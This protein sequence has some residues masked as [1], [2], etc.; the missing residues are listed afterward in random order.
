MAKVLL[1]AINLIALITYK[2]FFG[3][4]VTVDQNFPEMVNAGET[5]TIDVTIEK[6]DRQGFAKWQST[7][8]EGFI[9]SATETHGA[10]FSFKNQDVKVIWMTLPEEE[11]FTIS[12]EVKSD[13][14]MQ[15]S[16]E[17]GGK[18]SFI[19]ENERKDISSATKVITVGSGAV[20]ASENETSE[21]E[22]EEMAD[23]TESTSEEEINMAEEIPADSMEVAEMT[24]DTESSEVET[25]TNVEEPVAD[26][27]MAEG[28][29]SSTENMVVAEEGNILIKRQITHI[30]EGKYEVSLSINKSDYESFGKVEDYLPPNFI[31]SEINNE[32]GMFS[33]NNNVVKI[34]WMTIPK[35]EVLEVKYALESVSDDL[36]T[37]GIHGMFSFLDN[38]DSRQIQIAE[39]R[40]KNYF[41]SEQ[42]ADAS[43][44]SEEETTDVTED[45]MTEMEE[46]DQVAEESSENEEAVEPEIAE[47]NIE[48]EAIETTSSEEDDL[49]SEITNI[50]APDTDVNYRVQIAAAKREVTQQYFIDRHNIRENVTIEFHE[51]WYKYTIG[52]YGIYKEARD[53]RNEVWATENKIDDAF[54][55][56]YNAGERISVQEALMITKQQWFK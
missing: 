8:P 43:E 39:T 47:N 33:F 36:D 51:T 35:Q 55:T 22:E 7:L 15:G 2:L 27:T 3:G 6:G 19:E 46:S 28:S 41:V 10:T 37:A 11:S 48:T 45:S 18:F 53:K 1:V 38:D 5:F 56:A 13:P 17:M 49:V 34:L 23:N 26:E 25:D 50:P 16:F 42:M 32:D 52:S 21:E 44:E 40:F 29:G 31:A 12:Y 9:A 4:D 20:M 14:T 30:A 54:V 24:E